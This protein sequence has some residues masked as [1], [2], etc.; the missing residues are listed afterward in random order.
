[1]IVQ[2]R[3]LWAGDVLLTRFPSR[4]WPPSFDLAKWWAFKRVLHGAHRHLYRKPLDAKALWN[5]HGRLWLP[6]GKWLSGTHPRV[7]QESLHPEELDHPWT[8]VRYRFQDNWGPEQLELMQKLADENVGVGYDVRELLT[9]WLHILFPNLPDDWRLLD[10]SVEQR[11]CTTLIGYIL[12]MVYKSTDRSRVRPLD[13]RYVEDWT[14]ACLQNFL[15][16]LPAGEMGLTF[17]EVC[18]GD[19]RAG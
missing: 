7:I 18:G 15:S 3:D 9:I 13:G 17:E 8:I 1:M 16:A 4:Y 10:E 6:N 19:G 12:M 11:V 14:P 2:G 5:T